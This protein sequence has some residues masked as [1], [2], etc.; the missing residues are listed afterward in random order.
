MIPAIKTW[1]RQS[2]PDR[3][4]LLG[5]LGAGLVDSR[6]YVVLGVVSLGVGT[7]VLGFNFANEYIALGGEGALT[8][9]P[10]VQSMLGRTSWDTDKLAAFDHVTGHGRNS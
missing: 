5:A 8:N 4:R 1:A 7:L 2:A 6:R 3:V 9:L 10:S